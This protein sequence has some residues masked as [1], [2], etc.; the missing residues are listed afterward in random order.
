MDVLGLPVK[1]VHQE[2]EVSKEL[3]ENPVNKDL[4]VFKVYQDL[5]VCPEKKD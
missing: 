1:L 2:I 3:M 4:K 5:L